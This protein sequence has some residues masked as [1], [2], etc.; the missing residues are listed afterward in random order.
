MFPVRQVCLS[1]RICNCDMPTT[2]E[3]LAIN[4]NAHLTKSQ[5]MWQVSPV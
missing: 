3:Q 4:T 5:I 2:D 1:E